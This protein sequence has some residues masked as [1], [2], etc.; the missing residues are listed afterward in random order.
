M[1]DRS[2]QDLLVRGIEN[3]YLDLGSLDGSPMHDLLGHSMTCMDALMPQAQDA[4]ARPATTSPSAPKLAVRHLPCNPCWLGA[5]I[6][7]KAIHSLRQP[8]SRCLPVL[9]GKRTNA[10]GAGCAG[11]VAL[12]APPQCLHVSISML[13]TRLRRWAQVIAMDGMYAGC[14]GAKTGHGS[15]L[16]SR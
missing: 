14:A 16:F 5:T 8:A 1:G 7:A 10:V 13:N 9:L 6:V 4:Q 15:V 11:T 3:C 12:T 2:L